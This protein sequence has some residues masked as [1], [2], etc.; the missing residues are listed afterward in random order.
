M[1][2]Q[3]DVNERKALDQFA[4][5]T[6]KVVKIL[7]S[8]Q[9]IHQNSIK[10][11][12]NVFE[13]QYQL[14]RTLK[15]AKEMEKAIEESVRVAAMTVDERYLYYRIKADELKE[16]TESTKDESHDANAF[17]LLDRDSKYTN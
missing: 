8:L 9:K 4:K 15:S 1:N 6:K 7:E 14:T 17:T 2:E 3:E 16:E 5:R 10:K 12:T 13:V 11:K